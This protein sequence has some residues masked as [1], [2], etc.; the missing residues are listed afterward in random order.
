MVT[1]TLQSWIGQPVKLEPLVQGL[2][3]ELPAYVSRDVLVESVR[4]LAGTVLTEVEA[5]RLAWRLAGNLPRLR[6]GLPVHPWIV[7]QQ[8]E[9]VPLQILRCVST[10]NPR[11][12]IGYDFTF[13]ILAGTPAPLKITQFWSRRVAKYV[14]RQIGFSA[15]WGTYPYRFARD[16]VGLRLLGHVEAQLSRT[17]PVFRDIAG[18]NSLIQWNR[19]Q[20]LKLRLRVGQSCPERFTHACAR[21]PIGY[22]QCPAGTH[23]ETYE[24]GRCS[25]CNNDDALFDPEDT[26]P[27]CVSCNTR[28]R[29]R[30]E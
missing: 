10:K 12:Q 4:Y 2:A 19:R 24:I 21:C 16:M 14:A 11:G 30:R 29:M 15:P 27:D 7:Q 18:T 9:W 5:I 6:Q 8:D 13:R 17:V 20:V 23:A 3:A 28:H 1:R 25:R 26:L 22:R